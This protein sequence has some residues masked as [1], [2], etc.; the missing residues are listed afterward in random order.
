MFCGTVL[1]FDSTILLVFGINTSCLKN[2]SCC[3]RNF[4]DTHTSP[5]NSCL[6]FPNAEP[7]VVLIV[8]W[9]AVEQVETDYKGDVTERVLLGAGACPCAHVSVVY[10]GKSQSCMVSQASLILESGSSPGSRAAPTAVPL[11]VPPAAPLLLSLTVSMSNPVIPDKTD[12]ISVVFSRSHSVPRNKAP[13][14][15]GMKD[16]NI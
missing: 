6:R 12:R 3:R 9:T 10:V 2:K 16:G 8:D 13:F 11:S 15:T 14:S 5:P 7:E 4:A 1:C